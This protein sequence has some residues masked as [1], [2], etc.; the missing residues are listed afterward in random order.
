MS[1]ADSLRCVQHPRASG[2]L[3]ETFGARSVQCNTASSAAT[4]WALSSSGTLAKR[5]RTTLPR[6]PSPLQPRSARSSPRWP[7]PSATPPHSGLPSAVVLAHNLCHCCPHRRVHRN[8]HCFG[9]TVCWGRE[10]TNSRRS[11]QSPKMSALFRAAL[12]CITLFTQP[13]LFWFC[14]APLPPCSRQACA[15]CAAMWTL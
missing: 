8:V 10:P 12:T 6:S 1:R 14:N 7:T 3:G 5:A 13:A 4:R 2:A 9:T 15:A 11:P